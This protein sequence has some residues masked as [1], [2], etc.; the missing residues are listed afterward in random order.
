MGRRGDHSK[1]EIKNMAI[2]AAEKLAAENGFSQL[3]ARKIATEI[4]YTVG[5]LY[6]VFKNLDDLVLQVNIRTLA[7][8]S[9]K[10]E[11]VGQLDLE[12]KQKVVAM[13]HAY[14]DFA[15]HETN[16]WRMVFDHNVGEEEDLPDWYM[17]CVSRVFE[18]CEQI[19][20]PSLPSASPQEISLAARAVW[21]GAHGICML[22]STRKLDRTGVESVRGLAESLVE[23]YID[24]FNSKLIF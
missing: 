21:S 14:L 5:T 20:G 13:I 19:V 7:K 24:G 11:T 12:P 18:L 16:L 23:N 2:A 3:S 17:D 22:A 8:L 10:L 6:L 4:G 15:K 9:D 1:E